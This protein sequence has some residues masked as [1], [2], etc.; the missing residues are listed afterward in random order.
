M[1]L[2]RLKT[3]LSPSTAR[4]ALIPHGPPSMTLRRTSVSDEPVI[5]VHI[6]LTLC[7]S[8]RTM[9]VY[10]NTF[11]AGGNVL[12]NGTWVIFGGNQRKHG[13]SHRPVQDLIIFF[14]QLSRQVVSPLPMLLLTATPTEE[15]PSE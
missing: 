11:C 8:D 7:T 4:T 6:L 13:I 15:V 12:G 10:S 2:T 9:D 14:A 1:S 3:T 5:C